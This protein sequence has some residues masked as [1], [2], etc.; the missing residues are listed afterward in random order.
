RRPRRR[1]RADAPAQELKRGAPP[2]A[3]RRSTRTGLRLHRE[4]EHGPS[5]LLRL[6]TLARPTPARLAAL[7]LLA[8]LAALAGRG[9]WPFSY[10]DAFI[11]YRYARSWAA[12]DGLVYNRGE[13][14]LGT[15]A[16]GYAL[17]LGVLTRASGGRLDAPAW[18]TLLSLA[19]LVSAFALAG[20]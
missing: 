15:T 1:R 5:P 8:V 18:G 7:I 19:A 16:P 4:P 3:L 2:R 12:G 9:L 13:A 20:R 17:A 6:R 11:S 14:V 10:D